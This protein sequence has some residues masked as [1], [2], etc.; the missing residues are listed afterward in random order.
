MADPRPSAPITLDHRYTAPNGQ[1]LLS[2]MQALVRLPL[3]QKQRDA[4]A[5]YK[6]AGY[7]S[8]YRGSPIGGYDQ[9][10]WKAKDH[11]QAHD[12]VFQPGVNEDLAANAIWG[13][14]QLGLSR[15]ARYQGVFSLWYGKGPGADRSG[16]VFKH[17][18]GA[19]TAA[20]GGV[21]A[22]VGDD[23]ACK[24]STFPHQSEQALMAAMI[25]VLHAASVQDI[26]DYGLHGWALSRFSGCWV[27]LKL[28]S[29]VGDASAVVDI[30]PERVEP[31]IP[32][33]AQIP[34]GGLNLRWP[35]PPVQQEA[36]LIQ[37]KLP[38]VLAYARANRLDRAVFEA[39]VPR[40]GIMATG[41]AYQDVRSALYL[42]GLD[43]EQAQALG[44][45]LYKVAMP[46]PLEPHGASAFA[47]RQ[48]V[49]LVVEEK[50]AV[51][52]PQLKALMYDGQGARPLVMGKLDQAG[53]PL[54]P[55][56]G[57][58]S[59]R[60]LADII[61]A[62][63][64]AL[65]QGM[66]LVVRAEQAPEIAAEEQ[67]ERKPHFCSGCPHNT[68]TVV[69]EGSR[70]LGGIGCHYMTLWMDRQT[71]TFAQMGG[72]GVAWVGMAPFTD[73]PHVFANIGD[74]T[75]YHSGLMAI[76]AAV[77]GTANITYKILFNDAV[78][79]TGG[80][81]VDGPMDVPMITRQVAAEGVTHIVVVSDEP[82]K[83]TA[84]LLA[85]GV[86][87]FARDALDE[88]QRRMRTLKGVSVLIYDQTCAAEKRRRRKR[89]KLP[90]PARRVVINDLVCEGCG[91]C[92]LKSNCP[93]IVPLETEW[94]TKRQIDQNSCNK[95]FSCL[96]GFCPSF[97][98]VDGGDLAQ[99]AALTLAEIP[100]VPEPDIPEL[101]RPWYGLV[102]GIGG[103]GIIT[104]GALLAMAAHLEGKAAVTLDQTGMAQKGGA[105][106]SH[107]SLAPAPEQLLASRLAPHSA[108]L[109]LAGDLVVSAGAEGLGYLRSG[110]T[111]AIINQHEAILPGFMT[112][113][114]VRAPLADLERRLRLHLRKDAIT[115]EATGVATALL[116]DSI[117]ANLF[118]LGMAW[119][120]GLI[121][122][123]S[124]AL[125]QAIRLNDVQV[126][127]N[128]TAFQ[129]GR[130][131][132]HD[133][134]ALS[135][136]LQARQ[137]QGQRELAPVV[138][139]S[140]L[141]AR[142][143]EYLSAY[144]NKSYAQRYAALVARV[145]AA[146]QAIDPQAS[147]LTLAAARQAFRLMAYK[148][149]YEVA[150]LYTQTAFLRDLRAQFKG[151]PRLK[152]HFAPPVLARR[153]PHTGEP[154]KRA[155]GAWILPILRVLA[156]GKVVRG[157]VWDVFG[158]LPERKAERELR[159]SYLAQIEAL[160]PRLTRAT[161]P[162]AVALACVPEQ[163]RGFGPVKLRNM[164]AAR[165]E[166][167]RLQA[168]FD[169]LLAS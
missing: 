76:R 19:G 21:L 40:L 133:R 149:E 82:D 140:T 156:L 20:L 49:V 37:H 56:S 86:E 122:L 138:D 111:A 101:S 147:A 67:V 33:D 42:L 163:I 31:I 52:E 145:Q 48:Q 71:T 137:P 108:D 148:D 128:L 54:L 58:L 16:D 157:T 132:A 116:G 73:E 141:V 77:A 47:A 62:Q 24:S 96:K 68:S 130:L 88:V 112:T 97:V 150:R 1:V 57:E 79:M 127:M 113:Q 120:Q 105:V 95:D 100:A 51:I 70:A 9:A 142:R 2:A 103:T 164:A 45:S 22:V 118:L 6:T 115:I 32:D 110:K 160:L 23:H 8:G 85:P 10:L 26:L 36:R 158:L 27:G 161:L 55:E 43:E 106:L 80:Q 139:L 168:A 74:G 50:R 41:K 126:A 99:P 114:Q 129:L 144:Q 90:D 153:N 165:R 131:A 83:Y 59:V 155:F 61:A 44:L 98:T 7:I 84:A 39:A 119:Q 35:D 123:S 64:Q 81:P 78:A 15:G 11:L 89:G 30:S 66:A 87:V 91:D 38:A 159:D 152:F 124:A 94:G 69:P 154:E 167:V 5:G 28:T 63:L 34:A 121:P 14:Q 3:L 107:I 60:K 109:L 46:W 25:P 104:I 134:T 125:E 53:Q 117:G 143:V 65:G 136:L 102:T 18:N 13:T 135:V 12:I 92:S 162:A 93:S 17:A 75:Y 72:E 4:Q 151:S 146:E 169:S 166:Q 29:D